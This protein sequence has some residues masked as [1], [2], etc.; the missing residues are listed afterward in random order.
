MEDVPELTLEKVAPDEFVAGQVF[1][2]IGGRVN[3]KATHPN[4]KRGAPT[5]LFTMEP[6]VPV[7]PQG[8]LGE[9]V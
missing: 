2:A 7:D 9:P 3:I 5:Q 6:Y 4:K 1:T 8:R